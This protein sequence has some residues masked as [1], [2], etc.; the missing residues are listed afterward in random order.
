[1]EH[2]SK[3]QLICVGP[4]I[5]LY[6]SFAAL[7]L[8]RMMEIYPGRVYS[9]PEFTALP[10][11]I[12]SGADFALMPS[13]DEPFGLVA[14]EFGRKG[15]LCV[16]ARVGGLGQMPGWWF[17]I[18][19]TT[20][21]HIIHQFKIA[22]EEALSSKPHIRAIMRARAAKQRFPVAQWVEDLEKLQSTAIEVSQ[23]QLI[24]S[25]AQSI[26]SLSSVNTP[27]QSRAHSRSASKNVSRNVSRASSPIRD[28]SELPPLPNGGLGSEIG[29]SQVKKLKQRGSSHSADPPSTPLFEVEEAD[30]EEILGTQK[31]S[32][33]PLVPSLSQYWQT[34]SPQNQSTPLANLSERRRFSTDSLKP[35]EVPYSPNLHAPLVKPSVPGTT[36][37]ED[38]FAESGP[39]LYKQSND[40]LLSL[41]AVT[42][43]SS[44]F[45]L[46]HV[47]PFFTDPKKEFTG[48]YKKKLEKLN[49]KTSEAQLCIEE[50][51]IKSEKQW[52]SQMRAAQMG[53]S[54]PPSPMVTARAI[55]CHP[56]P[57]GSVF[58]D[59]RFTPQTPNAVDERETAIDEFLLGPDYVA[60]KGLKHIL[61]LRIVRSHSGYLDLITK[62]TKGQIIAATSYQITLLTGSVGQAANKLYAIASI[63]LAGSVLWWLLYRRLKTVYVLSLPFA[64]YGLAFLLIGL[65]PLGTSISSR[66]WIQNVATGFYAVA[67][68]SGSVYFAV[69]F[70]DEGGAP[71][72]SWVYRA[73][74]IQGTQQI[75]VVAL[76]YWGSELTKASQHISTGSSPAVASSAAIIPIGVIIA[77]LMWTIGIILLI[78]LP[79]YYRQAPGHIPSFYTALFGRKIIL[80]FFVVVI[81]QNYWLSAPYGRNWLYLWSSQHLPAWGV[82]I[83]VLI[84]FIAIWAII[85]Y[86]FS[87]LSTHHSWVLPVFAMGLGAPRWAQMLW[88]I[89]NI[90]TYVPWAGGPIASAVAGRCLWLWLGVLDAIQGVGFGM[91]LLQTLTRFHVLFTL[92]AAQVLG[93]VATILARA[94]APDKIGPGDVFPDFSAGAMPGLGKAWFWVAL[95]MNLA[96]P[97]GFFMFFR[98][99]QLSKP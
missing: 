80:W 60:P 37:S 25:A 92:I 88:G 86:I 39:N 71:V 65:A 64:L 97:A 99:E 38:W 29:P 85:L 11:Y 32:S 93:S 56:S 63:Y 54:L 20:T 41:S 62:L 26:F 49:G 13:R 24:K 35:Q 69:N 70:G 36:L 90:G 57:E 42:G 47:S 40:T 83:L 1:M 77:C 16:G 6:G 46:Q 91:I 31:R 68:A 8:A 87:V 2:N 50:Y 78:G 43:G 96:V 23:K 61:R 89:S 73:C 59:G 52:Y 98:K 15:A 95:L 28:N 45:K 21:K 48:Q 75:Y 66:G 74:V 10:P 76:W 17:T 7:K 34:P 30:N 67:S 44:D 79:K 51:L 5:D 19:S 58:E 9:K 12:F 14:V 33:R 3:V 55:E 27:T 81:I 53:K 22:C 94:T 4:V 18:E 72:T 82:V 84:F